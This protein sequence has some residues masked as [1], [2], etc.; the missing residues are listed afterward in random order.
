MKMSDAKLVELIH[1][2]LRRCPEDDDK[3]AA[4][5]ITRAIVRAEVLVMSELVVDS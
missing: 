5:M 1:S 2:V 4:E 3:Y